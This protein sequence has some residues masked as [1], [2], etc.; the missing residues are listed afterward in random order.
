MLESVDTLIAFILI[1]LVVSLLITIV[2]QMCAAALNLRGQNLLSALDSAF[3]AIA[4]SVEA[5]KRKLAAYLLKGGLLSDSFLPNSFL[6]KWKNNPV[7]SKFVAGLNH[8][9]HSNAIRPGE[10]FDAIHRIAIA[11]EPADANLKANARALLAALGVSETTL[12]YA[13]TMIKE[14]QGKAETISDD[15]KQALKGAGD[16][17][18]QVKEMLSMAGLSDDT[19]NKLNALQSKIEN[20][21]ERNSNSIRDANKERYG[22]SKRVRYSG[23]RQSSILRRRPGCRLREVPLLDLHL[24]GARTAVAYDAHAH[25]HRHLCFRFR[26]RASARHGGNLQARRLQQNSARQIGRAS[27]RGGNASRQCVR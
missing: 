15:A 24:R 20:V 5:E 4:P 22:S 21:Y 18:E 6:E 12:A 11:K 13:E 17:G 25:S 14:A 3:A 1:I 16:L 10:L 7:V 26:I 19:K 27:R 23:G 8:W 9:R 2:V